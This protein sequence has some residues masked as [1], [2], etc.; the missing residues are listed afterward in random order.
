[1]WLELE[2]ENIKK[3]EGRMLD[4]KF[5]NIPEVGSSNYFLLLPRNGLY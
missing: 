5:K 3:F 4:E 2:W 1:M